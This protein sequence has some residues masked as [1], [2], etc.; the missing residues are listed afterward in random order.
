MQAFLTY[1]S[2]LTKERRLG[3]SQPS[4][5]LGK[6]TTR[7]SRLIDRRTECSICRV[8]DPI[9]FSTFPPRSDARGCW[10]TVLALV[11]YEIWRKLEQIH[12]L[13]DMMKSL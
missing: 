4:S 13:V 3:T 10:L 12:R 1:H 2:P 11:L 7:V 9:D 8:I 5:F 6:V